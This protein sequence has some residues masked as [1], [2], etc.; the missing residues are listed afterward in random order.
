MERQVR[1]IIV[2][3]GVRPVRFTMDTYFVFAAPE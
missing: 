2:M 3:L 1:D